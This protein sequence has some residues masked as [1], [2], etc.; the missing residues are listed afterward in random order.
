MTLSH[1]DFS[2]QMKDTG[3]LCFLK[4]IYKD[5]KNTEL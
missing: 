5:T 4:W 3:R 2:E 1:S